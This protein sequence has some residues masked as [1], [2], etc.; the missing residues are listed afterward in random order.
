MRII[1]ESWLLPII[2]AWLMAT[3]LYA[4]LYIQDT[5]T[6]P[7]AEGYEKDWEFQLLMFALF[8]LP[9]LLL[10][11]FALVLGRWWSRRVPDSRTNS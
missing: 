10:A 4:Y 7:E 6:S 3:G 8:R 11:L 5:I 2:M 1:K 9:F